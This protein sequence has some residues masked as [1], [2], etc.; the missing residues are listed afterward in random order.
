MEVK[1][2]NH[3]YNLKLSSNDIVKELK[4]SFFM[5]IGLAFQS[6]NALFTDLSKPQLLLDLID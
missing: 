2:E 3:F 4:G 1:I 5:S 6:G